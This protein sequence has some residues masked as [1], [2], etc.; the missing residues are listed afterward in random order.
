MI[1]SFTS[2]DC[3]SIVYDSPVTWMFPFTS[4][5]DVIVTVLIPCVMDDSS[6]AL[7]PFT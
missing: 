2:R 5:F 6:N 7:L 4:R 3:E 1:R